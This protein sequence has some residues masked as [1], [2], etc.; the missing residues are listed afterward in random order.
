M[1]CTTVYGYTV[2]HCAILQNY[3]KRSH[4]GKSNIDFTAK[5]LIIK[6]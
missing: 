5:K 6:I 2:G 1:A 4:L 3:I